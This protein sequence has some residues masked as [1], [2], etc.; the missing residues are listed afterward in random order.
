MGSGGGRPASQARRTVAFGLTPELRVEHDPDA[1]A[2]AAAER[3][4]QTIRSSVRRAGAASVALS[5]GRTPRLLYERL[6]TAYVDTVPWRQVHVWW[7]DER[8]VPAE[9]PDSNLRMARETLIGRLPIP[10]DQIHPIPTTMQ[11]PAAAAD[12]YEGMLERAF[13]VRVPRFDLILLGIGGDGHTA[14]LYPHSSAVRETVRRVVVA[15]APTPP[16]TRLTLT[17]PVLN[18][19]AS[20]QF[21]ATG[22][23]K[24]SVIQRV[25]KG[26]CTPEECP[27][28]GVRPSDGELVWWVD[29]A[30]YPS[31]SV[32]PRVRR[33]EPRS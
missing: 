1:V 18:N 8:F 27:A 5:G 19:A 9:D 29:R 2:V 28:A 21:V 4:A 17:F 30:A 22:A 10:A 33:A 25:L 24:A 3:V 7:G 23:E 31:G 13:G 11:D 26:S 12:A 16:A 20:V 14:S 32:L 15:R 6:A